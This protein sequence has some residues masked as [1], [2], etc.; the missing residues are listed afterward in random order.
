M[1]FKKGLALVLALILAI[2]FVFTGCSPKGGA[3]NGTEADSD[4]K[5][6]VESIENG[7]GTTATTED[8]PTLSGAS[9]EDVKEYT[10]KPYAVLYN[11]Q[12]NFKKSEITEE[13]YEF[14]SPLDSLGRC[15]YAMACVGPETMP[16]EP[17]GSITSIKPTGWVQ[18]YYPDVIS[19]GYLYNRCHLIAYQLTGENKNKE[20]LITGTRYLNAD[21]M[22]PFEDM[23]A[24]HVNETGNH[25]MYRVTPIFEGNN[26]L[27]SGVQLE[28][29]SVEDN[30]DAIC[31]NVYLYNVQPGVVIDY[32]TGANHLEMPP[33]EEDSNDTPSGN[34]PSGG[35]DVGDSENVGGGDNGGDDVGGNDPT[36][37]PNPTPTPTPTPEPEPEPDTETTN[38]YVLNTNTKK[39]HYPDCSSAAKISEKNRA[40]YEGAISDLINNQGYTTCGNCRPQ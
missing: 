19:G 21:G 16:T 13:G 1:K 6:T 31:F 9:I 2:A 15:G 32:A 36:P 8:E 20:N 26:L 12:P 40:E 38:K 25:V 14:Y 27:A 24:D 4:I 35:N 3:S 37:T 5:E 22:I 18:Q 30:G 7:S 34:L 29:F 28:A 10:G 11:N 33:V 17:R 39:I 23:I